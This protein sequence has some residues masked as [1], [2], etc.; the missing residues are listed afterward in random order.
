ML[1]MIL[2]MGPV[3]DVVVLT[4]V[5]PLP[6]LL[7]G[8]GVGLGVGVVVGVGVGLGLGVVVGVGVGT[9]DWDIFMR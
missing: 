8:A 7:A 9:P 2:V 4:M 5:K 1:I 3:P 6:E